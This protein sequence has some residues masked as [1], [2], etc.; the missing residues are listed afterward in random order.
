MVSE[1][2]I[3]QWVCECCESQ[4]SLLFTEYCIDQPTYRA[5]SVV[6]LKNG[7]GTVCVIVMRSFLNSRG[8]GL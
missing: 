5:V 3:D 4:E 2:I 8:M 6:S 1:R 7:S